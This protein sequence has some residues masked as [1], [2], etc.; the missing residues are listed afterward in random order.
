MTVRRSN[1]LLA[2]LTVFATLSGG[3]AFAKVC[4]TEHMLC[5][6]TMP[7]DGYCEC[8]V[9]GNTEDGTVMA[10]AP[11]RQHVNATAAGCGAA[12]GSPGCR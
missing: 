11:P 10:K 12:P 7:V 1:H 9:H 6:T 5:P 8:R 4:Q 3:T 2:A